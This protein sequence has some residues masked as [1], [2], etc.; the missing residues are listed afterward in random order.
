LYIGHLFKDFQQVNGL[1]SMDKK[2]HQLHLSDLK[3]GDE[4]HIESFEEDDINLLRLRD[5]GLHDGI[6][7]RVVKFT[8]L[9]D[10]IEIKTRGFYLSIQKSMAKQ[11]VIKRK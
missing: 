5:M 3:A 8:P 10:S 1:K 2:E 7:F 6:A 9:G 11:I 4:A